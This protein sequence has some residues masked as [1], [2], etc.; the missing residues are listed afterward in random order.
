MKQITFEVRV[1]EC[2]QA[3]YNQVVSSG[4]SLLASSVVNHSETIPEKIRVVQAQH[5]IRAQRTTS[6]N[7]G[8]QLY[9]FSEPQLKKLVLDTQAN[10]DSSILMAPKVTVFAGQKATVYSGS[11]RPFVTGLE[12]ES[13]TNATTPKIETYEEGISMNF[14]TKMVSEGKF[15]LQ[16]NVEQDS[17]DR[18]DRFDMKLPDGSP[19]AVQIPLTTKTEFATQAVCGEKTH[20]VIAG[21]PGKGANQHRIVT[22]SSEILELDE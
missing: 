20:L 3:T 7:L 10:V 9:Q 17:I 4:G 5:S 6:Q 18:V 15:H 2:N 12:V 19:I 22:V 14:A 13:E 8:V 11:E 1:F 21:L 16:L